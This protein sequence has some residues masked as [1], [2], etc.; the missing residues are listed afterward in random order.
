[1]SGRER[2]WERIFIGLVLAQGLFYGLRHLVTAGLLAAQGREAIEQMGTAASGILLFQGMRMFALLV[3]TFFMGAGQR[4]GVILGAMIGAWNGVFS[5]LLF[6][7][8]A[9]VLTPTAVL[10]QPMLQVVIGALG[11]WLGALVWK[12]LSA[13][14]PTETPLPRRRRLLRRNRD[15]F[16]GPVAWF[17][18]AAGVIMAVAGTLMATLVFD[19]ILDIGNGTLATTDE[20]QDRLITLEIK[21]LALLFGG[22]LAGAATRNGLKQGFCVGLVSAVI[23]SGIEIRYVEHWLQMAA[24]TSLAAFSLSLAGGWFGSRLFPPI[25]RKPRRHGLGEAS[26]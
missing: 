20:V 17:R 15:L 3:S 8:P 6:T 4:K 5:V 25:I 7:D 23:L 16:R 11:G 14:D 12:P 10:G 13:T 21:A 1:M 24:Y 26:L 19:K 22:A 9:Q 2:P 18:V